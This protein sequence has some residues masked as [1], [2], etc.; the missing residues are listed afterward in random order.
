MIMTIPHRLPSLSLTC[1][2]FLMLSFGGLAEELSFR[3]W[4]NKKG[5][6]VEG[7]LAEVVG[8]TAYLRLEGGKIG[9]VDINDLSFD[10]QQYLKQWMMD[11]TKRPDGVPAGAWFHGGK[12]YRVVKEKMTWKE[13]ERKARKMGGE[14]ARFETEYD[15][16]VLD[17]LAE[18]KQYFWIGATDEA[19]EGK[20]TWTDGS[21]VKIS[22]WDKDQPSNG[23][24]R[25]H[26]ASVRP[27]GKWND[28]RIDSP[29]ITGFIVM[30]QG[31]RK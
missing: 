10:D 20:W 1:A 3:T 26:F 9:E 29:S 16:E 21:P 14:L 25:E 28:V 18:S 27:G 31:K 11:P 8:G 6:K 7:S 23:Q 4:T 5:N 22:N 17:L 13:A 24:N 12:W 2:V 19:M 15:L 30:W